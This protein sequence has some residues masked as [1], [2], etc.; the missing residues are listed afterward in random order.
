MDLQPAALQRNGEFGA[1]GLGGLPICMTETLLSLSR[2]PA[3]FGA[4]VS[5]ILPIPDI[6]ASAGAGWPVTVCGDI[7]QMPGLGAR[8]A[9]MSVDIDEDGRTVGLF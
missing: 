1:A 8:P 4:P 7:Q 2:D 3:L 6:R 5:C 9:A